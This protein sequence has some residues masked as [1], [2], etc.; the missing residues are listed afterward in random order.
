MEIM[1]IGLFFYSI[2]FYIFKKV[3]NGKQKKSIIRDFWIVFAIFL[4]WEAFS[5]FYNIKKTMWEDM[6]IFAVLFSL[7]LLKISFILRKQEE[8]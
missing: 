3:D 1:I 2:F 5:A 7:L 4:G 6:A 8:K